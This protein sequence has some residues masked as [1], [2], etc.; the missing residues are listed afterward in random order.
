MDA[1]RLQQEINMLLLISEGEITPEID[2]LMKV[3]LKAENLSQNIFWLLIQ[4]E[5]NEALVKAR[6][7]RLEIVK[8]KLETSKN[9]ALY[10]K[11]KIADELL[12]NNQDS[13]K[14]DEYDL[15]F[16]RS[17]SVEIHHEGSIPDEYL[18]VKTSKAPNKTAIKDA[19]KAG[20][21]VPGA[22][23]QQNSNL[24]IKS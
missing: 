18:T 2:E 1:N 19:I 14:L 15:S 8:K 21:S 22:S 17:E 24:Q 7:E 23:L 11:N 4:Y 9:S 10:F 3:Q 6:S 20:K 16:R 12:R 13:L 5:T